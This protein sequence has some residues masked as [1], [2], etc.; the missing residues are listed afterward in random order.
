MI[1]IKFLALCILIS[2]SAFSQ[3]NNEILFIKDEYDKILYNSKNLD[4]P[5]DYYWNSL[6]LDKQGQT[7][8]A[9]ELLNKGLDK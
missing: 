4:N 6:I 3:E 9:I 7:L 2:L 1:K 8:K 5:N